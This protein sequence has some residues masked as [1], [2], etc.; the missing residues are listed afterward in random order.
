MNSVCGND[1]VA[2]TAM[3]ELINHGCSVIGN[4]NESS[5]SRR[6]EKCLQEAARRSVRVRRSQKS[7]GENRFGVANPRR[8]RNNPFD[9]NDDGKLSAFLPFHLRALETFLCSLLATRGLPP[10]LRLHLA[11]HLRSDY[12]LFSILFPSHSRQ[13]VLEFSCVADTRIHKL[14]IK[15]VQLSWESENFELGSVRGMEIV[16]DG[17][18]SK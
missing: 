6:P 5:F 2:N 16:G 3:K 11:S 8:R 15:N 18:L 10:R 1:R 14:K 7:S 4:G 13:I 17:E 9:I 12:L